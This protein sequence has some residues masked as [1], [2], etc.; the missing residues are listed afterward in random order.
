MNT[1]IIDWITRKQQIALRLANGECDGSYGEAVLIL[2]S[3]L[4]ALAATVWPGKEIDRKRF[5]ELLKNFTS[6]QSVCTL[7]SVPLLVAYLR[8]KGEHNE[9]KQLKDRFLKFSDSLVLTGDVVDKTEKEIL[10][11]CDTISQR[12]IR[13]FSYANLLY[14]EIRSGYVHEYGPGNKA[15][16]WPMTSKS[17]VYVSYVNKL[18]EDRR[19][20]FHIDWLL[21]ISSE[22]AQ[23]VSNLMLPL[24]I[25]KVWWIDGGQQ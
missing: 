9:E 4:N 10:S 21:K 12:Y 17:N 14:Q 3:A 20:H 8:N 11:V 6:S 19:I 23:I 16:T 2:C 13:T 5:I 1:W 24:E 22:T 15:D 7:I 18:G 25:P